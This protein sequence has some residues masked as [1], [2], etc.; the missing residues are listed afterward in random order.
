M[1]NPPRVNIV[2]SVADRKRLT[3]FFVILIT[4][5][6]RVNAR[7]RNKPKAKKSVKA[8]TKCKQI[9]SQR[10]ALFFIINRITIELLK[11]LFF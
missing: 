4:V 6:R 9:G 5:D 1:R 11:N 10:R 2:L 8:K 7:P 3:D